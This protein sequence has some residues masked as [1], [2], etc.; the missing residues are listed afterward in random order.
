VRSTISLRAGDMAG[1]R[2]DARRALGVVGALVAAGIA[3]FLSTCTPRSITGPGVAEGVPY[4][5]DPALD[6]P[7]G[8]P[9][10][11]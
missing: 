1:V 7:L 4:A 3:L 9:A 5:Y 10:P 11:P 6:P 8:E 2:G